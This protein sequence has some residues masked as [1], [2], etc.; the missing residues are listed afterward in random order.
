MK[1]LL[2]FAALVAICVQLVDPVSS[3]IAGSDEPA[4]PARLLVEKKILNK[5]LVESRD[6]IVNYQIFNVGGR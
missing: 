4:S 5:Y 1:S 6:I 2:V 3:A